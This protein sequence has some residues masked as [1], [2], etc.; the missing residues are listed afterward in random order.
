M[1]LDLAQYFYS[2]SARKCRQLSP[3]EVAFSLD[4]REVTWLCLYAFQTCLRRTQS[5]Y[6]VILRFLRKGLSQIPLCHRIKLP[7]SPWNAALTKLVRKKKSWWEDCVIELCSG[8]PFW[9]SSCQCFCHVKKNRKTTSH[10]ISVNYLKFSAKRL[11]MYFLGH[12]GTR[13]CCRMS[14]GIEPP[15]ETVNV[16]H[17]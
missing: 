4:E 3:G 5:R 9:I 8:K 7:D 16:T 2:A 1:I 15:W 17:A 10:G 13:T 6:R 11:I 14:P 12:H